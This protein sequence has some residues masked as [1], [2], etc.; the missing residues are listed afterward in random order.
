MMD[1]T[2][3]PKALH[4]KRYIAY[5][6]CAAKQGSTQSLRRQIRLIRE[7]GDRLKMRY[8]D[9][10][11]LPGVDGHSLVLRWDLSVLLARKC[12]QDDYDILVMEDPARLTRADGAGMI[13]ALFMLC[14]VQIVYVATG[15]DARRITDSEVTM[16]MGNQRS[17]W[18]KKTP[19]AA[20]RLRG[21]AYYRHS[22]K[23]RQENSVAIQQELVQKLAKKNGVA[24][25]QEFTE[26]GKTSKSA[27]RR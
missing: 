18:A 25:I 9:E 12:N 22:A 4:G 13:E 20:P 5:A 7:F 15:Q 24:I 27:R 3:N 1:A 17:Q 16:S 23:D 14:G 21:M 26:H 2:V 10:V 8:V 6:R 11:R 19:A